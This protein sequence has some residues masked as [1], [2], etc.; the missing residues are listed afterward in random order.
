MASIANSRVIR[1]VALPILMAALSLFWVALVLVVA[2][3]D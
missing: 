2:R 3:L 1:A